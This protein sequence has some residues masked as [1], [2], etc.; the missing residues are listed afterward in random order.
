MPAKAI[1][2]I[3]IV[4]GGTA[5]W[6]TAVHLAK[7]LKPNQGGPKVTLL[8]SPNIPTVGVGEGTVPAMRDS[9][10]YL[11]IS[12][13]DFIRECDAT[14]KQSIKF[15]DWLRSPAEGGHSYHHIFD[16]PMKQ[17]I[18]LSP[19]YHLGACGN[20]SYVDALSVQGMMCDKGYGPKTMTH[21]EY[22]GLTSYAYHLDA[23][24]FAAYLT[25]FGVEKLGISHVKGE[26]TTVKQAEDGTI[27][28]LS[29]DTVGELCADIFIDC[30]GFRSLL[31]GETL[32]IP[33]IDKSHILFA[34]YALAA[35]LPYGPDDHLPCHTIATAK[36]AGWIWDIG[37]MERRGTGYVYSSHHTSH[38]AAEK[39][40]R[41]Y[42]RVSLGDKA[43]E[44]STRQIKMKVGYRE[45][46]WEKNCIAVGLSQGF[47]EP[48]EATGLLMFDATARMLAEQFPATTE[49]IPVV[50]DRFNQRL[51]LTW[52]KVIDFIKLH[53]C[54]SQRTDSDFWLDNCHANSIPQSLQ[55]KL[56]YWQHSLPSAYDF[57]SR[58]EIF[59][60]ENYQYVLN[61]M[62]FK[63]DIEPLKSRYADLAKAQDDFE[64]I[65]QYNKQLEPQLI[66]HR[67]L[68][69]RIQ[70]YGLQTL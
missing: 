39:V 1:D 69:R 18:D 42:A 13:T 63:T 23:A 49:T 15:V 19:Y 14:F 61:G 36:E 12:E 20:Q 11:G 66:P 51:K 38:E 59:N 64:A 43:D 56:H 34:D 26:M 48:L 55:D 46:L 10:K 62:E 9:L 35:Q 70:K 21:N 24:K 17:D 57:S 67:D 29:T 8:E 30:T 45:K 54:T 58:L 28:S 3:L 52:D 22:E 7:H 41:D 32:D 68:I 2:H 16:Y 4:G 5:G 27:L 47:V 53:Y 31:L 37:L 44:I 40:I 50:A 60:L 65:Q 25:K 33:F 6:L